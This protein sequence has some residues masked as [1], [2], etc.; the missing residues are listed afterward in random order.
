MDISVILSN[1]ITHLIFALIAGAAVLVAILA[2]LV[3]LNR[4]FRK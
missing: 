1:E 3:L 2:L 4:W